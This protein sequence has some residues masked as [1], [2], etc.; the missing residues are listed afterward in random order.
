[1]KNTRFLFRIKYKYHIV[2]NNVAEKVY[3][4]FKS[5]TFWGFLISFVAIALLW[6]P[7]EVLL[8]T[9]PVTYPTS[10]NEIIALRAEYRKVLLQTI[11]GFVVLT[12]LYFTYRRI[13]VSEEGLI[14]ERFTRAI[15]HLGSDSLAI[16][17]GGIYA[18]ERI[19]ADSL[20]DSHSVLDVLSAYVR[21]NSAMP[22]KPDLANQTITGTE[23]QAILKVIGRKSRGDKFLYEID[24]S[25]TFL[26][27]A[28]LLGGDFSYTNFRGSDL[29]G[30]N[31]KF[32]TLKGAIFQ[33]A[34]LCDANLYSTNLNHAN[35][36][37]CNLNHAKLEYTSFDSASLKNTSLRNAVLYFTYFDDA[38]L[39]GA[40][41]SDALINNVYFYG[42][43]GL[44]K[45]QLAKAAIIQDPIMKEELLEDLRLYKPSLIS[46]QE[47]DPFEDKNKDNSK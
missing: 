34:S 27:G 8:E 38:Q 42:A 46:Y 47:Q 13:K 30:A 31:L 6:E 36:D 44:S 21:V 2:Y 45:E 29:T 7:V 24:L 35:L 17:L 5:Y 39:S 1:M 32:A 19:A 11:A 41:F 16:R 3:H 28:D 14:T 26:P 43:E 18:L 4:L 37:Y 20:R 25:N 15:E 22:P 33:A 12:G 9:Y 40:D 10:R 23:I